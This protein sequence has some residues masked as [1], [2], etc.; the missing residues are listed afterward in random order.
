MGG[1]KK[2]ERLQMGST[3]RIP[4]INSISFL[5]QDGSKATVAVI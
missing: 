5:L 4:L 2:L 3:S 1:A